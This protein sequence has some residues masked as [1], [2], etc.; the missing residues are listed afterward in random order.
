M[1]SQPIPAP[2][3]D[4][5]PSLRGLMSAADKTKLDAITGTNTGNVSIGTANGLSLNGQVISLAVAIASG[6]AGAMSGA[7]KAKLDAVL[8]T[9]TGD[10]TLGAVGSSPN[11]NGASLNGQVLTLQP[12]SGTQPGA[13]TAGT[14]TIGGD[15]TFTGSV[16][17]SIASGSNAFAAATGARWKIGGGT[18][19]YLTSDGSGK[20]TAAGDLA[21]ASTLRAGLTVWSNTGYFA[22]GNGGT[23]S[24]LFGNASD[25]AG[26]ICAA[27]CNGNTISAGDDRYSHVFYRDNQTNVVGC[28][29]TSGKFLAPGGIGVGNSAS[30]TT[31]GSVVKKIQVFD[32][33]GSSLGYLAVYSS[34]T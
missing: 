1:S 32:A 7:D 10:V 19:D 22:T 27:S 34:I 31:P 12:A 8:G 17:S 24:R 18:T 26:A 29:T 28:V 4:A 25:G 30:A 5:S 2:P 11:A 20:I 15:K 6:S 3:Q 23:P 13:L 21:A 9:N 16:I 33:S 14:Q